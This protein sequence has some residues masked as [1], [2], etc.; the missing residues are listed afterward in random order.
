M[1]LSSI[2]SRPYVRTISN[3]RTNLNTGMATPGLAP[4]SHDT[5]SFKG[6][7]SELLSAEDA[8]TAKAKYETST[9]GYREIYGDKFND[10]LVNT[11][12]NAVAKYAKDNDIDVMGVG[13][14]TR[15]ATVN[16]IP[17]IVNTLLDKGI[18]VKVP[19]MK[20]EEGFSTPAASPVLAVYGKE[21]DVPLSVLMTASHNPWTYGGYNLL[22][23][24]GAVA[25]DVVT[26]PIAE[27]IVKVAES[28]KPVENSTK[29]GE[30]TYFDPYK[31]YNEYIDSK[32]L[33]NY[34]LIKSAGI[35]I[36][37]DGLEGT[38]NYYFPWMMNEHGVSIAK[39]LDT[40]VEGPEPNAKNL[41]N[42]AEEVKK[43]DAKL[44]IGLA[45]DGDSDRFGLVDE[46]G[47]YIN[48][49]DVIMLVAYHMIKN[50]GM[51]KG[52]IIRNCAT[53]KRIDVL[54]DYFNKKDP[55]KYDIKVE[56]T[57][58]GFKYLGDK[59][60]ELEGSEHEVIV[61]GEESGGLTIR[62]HIPEKDGFVAIS[63]ILEL[64][65]AEKK[66]VGQILAE[67]KEEAGTGYTSVAKK[68][69][70]ANEEA[71]EAGVKHFD[72]YLTGEVDNVAGY[73]IDFEKT[74]A[75]A[76]HI[77]EY[78]KQGDG[79][80]L[81]LENGTAVLIR[82]SGTEPIVRLTIDSA[83]DT[84]TANLQKALLAEMKE[85]GGVEK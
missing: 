61:A 35:E 52:T 39:T 19:V 85:V 28:G 13:G 17:Q 11:M 40:H 33:I 78:K 77:K 70:F 29:R 53:S 27:N 74:K 72:K 18:D 55:E 60:V 84:V 7:D 3:F 10:K 63:K 41:A 14:D 75:A 5:V 65:A 66:P 50:E 9:S 83:D 59:M 22:T 51:N 37:Y 62:N 46:N 57:P 16:Y 38:G 34:D 69:G 4:L 25:T 2:Q 21:H 26:R 71:K 47:N 24:E 67:L 76:E 15:K 79:T 58:V 80:K 8:K 82:K 20:E 43:S 1:R 64:V 36:F 23:S 81:Y 73:K 44:K 68:I 45:T 12:T 30:L 49:N 42:L 32:K 31:E 48:S 6:R 54:A 56:E